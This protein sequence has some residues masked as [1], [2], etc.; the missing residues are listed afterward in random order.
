MIRN[1][2]DFLRRYVMSLFS[3][4]RQYKITGVSLSLSVDSC[5]KI[6][7]KPSCKMSHDFN[8]PEKCTMSRILLFY[9]DPPRA[10][11]RSEFSFIKIF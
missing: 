1:D 6:I 4:K 2:F 9:K 5:L 8:S 10:C 11:S 7:S 3:P